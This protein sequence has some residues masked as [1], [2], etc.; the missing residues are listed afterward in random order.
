MLDRGISPPSHA[1]VV[2]KEE[3]VGMGLVTAVTRGVTNTGHSFSSLLPHVMGVMLLGALI[4]GVMS[5]V[6][7]PH[8]RDLS[9]LFL[10]VRSVGI[11][12]LGTGV[13]RL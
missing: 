5:S 6:I 8:G 1:T 9:S 3:S 13:M 7:I 10:F 4:T 12:R 11:T 2:T